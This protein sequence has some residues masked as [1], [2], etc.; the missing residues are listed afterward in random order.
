MPRPYPN[1]LR[2]R[3]GEKVLA[4]ESRRSVAK[5]LRAAAF[6]RDQMGSTIFRHGIGRPE[7]DGHAPRAEAC[8][9]PGLDP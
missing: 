1:D 2:M 8:G 9:M 7:P 4:G 6:E 5:E 3:A